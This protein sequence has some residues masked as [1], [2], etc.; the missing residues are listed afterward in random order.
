MRIC[1]LSLSNCLFLSKSSEA[2]HP[3][4]RNGRLFA[5]R[6]IRL[7]GRKSLCIYSV[8]LNN[9]VAISNVARPKTLRN[10]KSY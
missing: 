9:G 3:P 10:S 2:A 4:T 7:A 6:H 5:F 8:R 1:P